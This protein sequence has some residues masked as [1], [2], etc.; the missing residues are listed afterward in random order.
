MSPTG[1]SGKV[2]PSALIGLRWLARIGPA[3]LDALGAALGWSERLAWRWSGQLVDAGWVSRVPMT[4][5]SGS[6]LLVTA[7]GVEM[8]SAEM[9]DVEIRAPRRPAPMSWAHLVACGWTAAW[10]TARGRSIQGPR[11]VDV[12]ERWHGQI[13]W[14]ESRGQR[15]AGHR[16][17][18]AWLPEDRR[19]AIE[20]ELVR[21]STPRLEA[22]LDLHAR[23]RSEGQTAGVIYVCGSV[24]TR[25]RIVALADERGLSRE[26]GGG[27]RVELLGD[28]TEQAIAAGEQLRAR[29]RR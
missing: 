3:P 20:V 29:R 19:I 7:S 21:K 28:V 17:D 15:E 6:L 8:A 24:R 26:T 9:A 25:E 10:L 18:L 22:I 5:G 11:E 12:D 14:R 1:V 23:W 13:R 16:P 4:H 2:T 27:L